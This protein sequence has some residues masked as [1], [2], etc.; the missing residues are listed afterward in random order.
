MAGGDTDAS[1][2]ADEAHHCC[3]GVSQGGERWRRAG[4][5]ADA[6]R[7]CGALGSWSA[8][9]R[10]SPAAPSRASS[11]RASRPRKHSTS[12]W[13]PST[14]AIV[15]A[16]ATVKTEWGARLIPADELER[17]LAERR[18]EPRTR[19]RGPSRSG[20][21]PALPPEIVARIHH[22][23][24]Y[25]ASLAEIARRLDRDGIPTGQGGTPVVAVDGAC[26]P[27][28]LGAAPLRS[29]WPRRRMTCVEFTAGVSYAGRPPGF[30]TKR[31]NQGRDDQLACTR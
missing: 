1:Q 4:S 2:D 18:E 5:D 31:G 20:R 28:P 8:R 21:K 12:A 15:P 23:H 16:I 30:L 24:A 7:N 9:T 13:R 19:N 6:R 27:P 29:G 25:G 3:T 11:T 26:G 22:E 17:Y 10:A 14:G